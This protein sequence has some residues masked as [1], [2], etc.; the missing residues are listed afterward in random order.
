[1]LFDLLT[2]PDA[3]SVRPIEASIWGRPRLPARAQ[4]DSL[5]KAVHNHKL[6]APW[7]G[8][9]HVARIVPKSTR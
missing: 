9:Q 3:C 2:Y 8:N 4:L 7:L 6:T 5:V 1:M